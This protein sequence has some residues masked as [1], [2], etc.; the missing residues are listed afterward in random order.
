MDISRNKYITGG[1]FGAGASARRAARG[2]GPHHY[3][4][5]RNRTGTILERNAPV[6]ITGEQ[7]KN[8]GAA[9]PRLGTR[10]MQIRGSAEGEMHSLIP[11]GRGLTRPP[12]G[13][14]ERIHIK[15]GEFL[16]QIEPAAKDVTMAGAGVRAGG[17][18]RRRA[19]GQ[20]LALPLTMSPAPGVVAYL[21][22]KI[23]VVHGDF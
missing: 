4:N 16:Y 22:P 20:M 2:G 1:L 12:P 11:S 21:Q 17:H 8:E 18:T 3:N 19:G 10:Q 6:A 14:G 7:K 15:T 23:E 5:L 9:A 13:V